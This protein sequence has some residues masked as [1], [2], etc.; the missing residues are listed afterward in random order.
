VVSVVEGRD[1]GRLFDLVERTGGEG[2]TTVDRGGVGDVGNRG[3]TRVVKCRGGGMPLIEELP[4]VV[5]IRGV[6]E[7][8]DLADACRTRPQVVRGRLV[9]VVVGGGVASER[10][11]RLSG[12]I[13]LG[14]NREKL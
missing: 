10:R 5:V 11:G 8:H 7:A 13:G 9:A 2:G 12:G 6:I 4:D 3:K 14:G 1:R